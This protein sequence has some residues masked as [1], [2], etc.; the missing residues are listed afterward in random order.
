M[1]RSTACATALALAFAAGAAAAGEDMDCYN[2]KVDADSRYTSNTP[3][4]LRITE[5]DIEKMLADI[6]AHEQR[7]RLLAQADAD[8]SSAD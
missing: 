7:T 8:K 5:A 6:R 3:E 2:D 1:I 4:V